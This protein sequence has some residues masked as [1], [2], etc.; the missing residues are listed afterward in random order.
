MLVPIVKLLLFFYSWVL[1]HLYTLLNTQ[2]S[3]IL[4]LFRSLYDNQIQSMANGTFRALRN[5]QTL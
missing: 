2:T 4:P 1:V 5:L 3:H